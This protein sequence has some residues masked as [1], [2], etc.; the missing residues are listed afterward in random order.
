[1]K[2]GSSAVSKFFLFIFLSWLTGNPILAVIVILAV[3]LAVDRTY[4]GFLPDP[5]RTF[6]S[7]GRIRELKRIVAINPHD[8]RSLKEL[9]VFMF[10][11]KNYQ[12]ALEYFSLASSKMCDDPE[13]NYYHGIALARNGSV[14]KGRMLVDSALL[15]APGLKY[16]DPY[17]AMA[18]VYIDNGAYDT[19]VPFL[20]QFLKVRVSSAEGLY[21]MG[22]VKIKTGNIDE[23]RAY[24]GKA[25]AAF[26][27]SPR[28]KRK[29]ERK[30]AWK[31]RLLQIRQ[32][33]GN[34]S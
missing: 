15:A 33:I 19:A 11:R 17:L 21:Q 20:E 34:R 14:D 16:G 6:R 32:V 23:G 31:A 9:G 12:K 2:Y 7:S 27:D 26:K 30:W 4:Y 29:L 18:E 8:A 10:E 22:L 24:L 5:L 1:M 25:V 28:Y 3:Y 13:F